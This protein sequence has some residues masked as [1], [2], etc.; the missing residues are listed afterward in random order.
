MSSFWTPE[1]HA[2]RDEVRHFLRENLSETT[3]Q[4]VRNGLALSRED[5]EHWHDALVRKGWYAG[6]WPEEHGGQGWDAAQTFIFADEYA[7][8]GA[9]W[10]LP[11][12]V[13]YVG[14][15]IFTFGTEAQKRRFLPEI[16]ANRIR[17]CQGYSEPDAGSDLASLRTRAV[18]EGDHYIV[19][20]AK[21][22]TSHAH[23]ADWMF[24][25]VRTG[26]EGRPQQ[27]ISFLL[28]DMTTPGIELRPIV[29]IEGHHHVN[30][31]F[32]KDV[33]V[34][35]E[36]LVGQENRGWT[37]AKF[38]LGHE[39]MLSADTGK[40]RR[41]LERAEEIATRQGLAQDP[42]HRARIAGFVVDLKALEWLTLRLLRAAETQGA[43][44]TGTGAQPSETRAPGVEASMLKIRGSELQQRIGEYSY[45]L[46]GLEGAAFTLIEPAGEE[47]LLSGI[48]R[49]MLLLK[50]TT[51]WGGSN[52]IQRNIIAQHALGLK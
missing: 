40:T 24:C 4:R 10:V 9:P 16:V 21:L 52:E 18:R 12:G 15:V 5:H 13:N 17:F 23:F 51:I 49:D 25:L 45:D 48:A 22:W 19:N 43:G 33:R 47:T 36:N 26:T 8:H 1:Q 11:Y 32:L 44:T 29:T 35:V 39:R 6:F 41:L 50:A 27:G 46:L 42:A 2:F 38:L 30:A 3:R 37:Y 34:P 14:P 20:G 28:I 7:Y 31:V